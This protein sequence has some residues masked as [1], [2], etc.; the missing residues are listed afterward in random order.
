MKEFDIKAFADEVAA[1]DGELGRI[2]DYE[3][4]DQGPTYEAWEAGAKQWRHHCGEAIELH[5]RAIDLWRQGKRGRWK[6]EQM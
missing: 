4:E 5:R 2:A 3:G 1:I 6:L